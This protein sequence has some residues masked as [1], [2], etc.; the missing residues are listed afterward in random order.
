MFEYIALAVCVFC[1]LFYK[2][3]WD[4]GRM[5]G[6]AIC[7][8]KSLILGKR[9]VVWDRRAWQ[10]DAYLVDLV[11]S[12]WQPQQRCWVCLDE[13]LGIERD[14]QFVVM[15]GEG[16]KYEVRKCEPSEKV[17]AWAHL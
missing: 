14:D 16:G 2:V 5:K 6:M 8:P 4:G 12:P 11:A 13:T 9:Y 7:D 3:G 1:A 15:K 10:T 17:D